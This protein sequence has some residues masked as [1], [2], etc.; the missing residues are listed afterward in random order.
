M[1]FTAA[2]EANL[3]SQ[4]ADLQDTAAKIFNMLNNTTSAKEMR[5]LAYIR[6]NEIS[7]LAARLTAVE[8]EVRSLASQVS[9]AL[10]Q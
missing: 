10:S 5:Q 9:S 1:S 7:D 4:M 8:A 6:Q 3:L 2:Q